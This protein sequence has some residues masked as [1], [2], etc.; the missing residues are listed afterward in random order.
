MTKVKIIKKNRFITS[1]EADGHTGYGVSGEDVVCAALSSIIQTAVLGLL[2]VA[3]VNV[4]MERDD[5]AGYIKFVLPKNLS[6]EQKHDS[7]VILSTMLVGVSDL[8]E[9]YSDFIEL[10]VLDNVY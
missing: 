3:G 8:Y 9:S 5:K 6:E 10:E 7:D 2:S 1:V 4:E